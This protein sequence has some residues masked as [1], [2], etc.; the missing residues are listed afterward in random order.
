MYSYEINKL[1]AR[2]VFQESVVL[3]D[4]QDII[5]FLAPIFGNICA[6]MMQMNVLLPVGFVTNVIT[7]HYLSWET[8]RRLLYRLEIMCGKIIYV[9]KFCQVS[10]SWA[11]R[12]ANGCLLLRLSISDNIKEVRKKGALA[13]VCFR[14][15]KCRIVKSSPCP[16][17]CFCCFQDAWW[18]STAGEWQCLFHCCGCTL[19]TTWKLVADSFM[20]PCEL[21]FICL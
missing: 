10:S 21:R 6:L 16:A 15:F 4:R 18:Y 13:F 1:Q 17:A 11:R 19:Q 12:D 5:R 3:G 7:L 2:L 9:N 20:D 14:S 8:C